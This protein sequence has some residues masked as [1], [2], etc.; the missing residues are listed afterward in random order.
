MKPGRAFI[1]RLE[2]QLSLEKERRESLIA[3]V[4]G[5]RV[6]S[7]ELEEQEL[8]VL[9]AELSLALSKLDYIRFKLIN[10]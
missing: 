5:G 8:L 6:L 1:S 2:R 9:E 3:L 4:N 10:N 7:I